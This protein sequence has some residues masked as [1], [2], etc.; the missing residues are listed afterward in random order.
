MPVS[1]HFD[2]GILV[3]VAVG[4]YPPEELMETV[5]A[6][7]DKFAQSG[8]LPVL[9]DQRRSTS[10]A[11]RSTE[12]LKRLAAFGDSMSEY[13]GP[14]IAMVVEGDLEFG[15]DRMASAFMDESRS[16]QVCRDLNT[17]RQWLLE[18]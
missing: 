8:R 13:V 18:E 12:D 3:I 10:L 9:F 5:Q 6:A 15:L 7:V 4:E 1:F 2:E 16:V 14:R 17:A 11:N